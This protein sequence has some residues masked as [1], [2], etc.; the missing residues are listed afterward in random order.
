MHSHTQSLGDDVVSPGGGA[1]LAYL[2]AIGRDPSG[3]AGREAWRRQDHARVFIERRQF[4]S[5]RRIVTNS[6]WSSRVLA[7]TYP[8][9][10]GPDTLHLQRRGHGVLLASHPRGAPG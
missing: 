3:R 8:F 7:E 9:A 4:R 2:R 5:A 6:A 10:A 1:Y